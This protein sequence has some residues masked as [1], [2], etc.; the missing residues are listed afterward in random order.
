[1]GVLNRPTCLLGNEQNRNLEE[2]DILQSIDSRE[3]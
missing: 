3:L 2:I 1:M